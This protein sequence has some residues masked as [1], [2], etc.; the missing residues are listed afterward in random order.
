MKRAVWLGWIFMLLLFARAAHADVRLEGA[1]PEADK[2]VSLDADHMPR[3]EAVKRLADAAGWS[4]VVASSSKE[5]KELVDIHVKDQP[6]TKVL[7]LVLSEGRFIA[8]R[9]GNLVLLQADDSVSPPPVAPPPPP[10][11]TPPSPPPP[12]PPPAAAPAKRGEDRTVTGGRLEVKRDEV[13]HDV[14]VF[15]GS[16]DVYGTVTGDLAV[17]G[18]R[19]EVHPGAHIVG[20]ATTVGGSLHIRDGARVDGDV[21]VVG[22]SLRRD[23]KAQVGGSIVQGSTDDEDDHPSGKHHKGGAGFFSRVFEAMGEAFSHAA[24]LFVFG[25]IVL[26]LGSKRI[27]SLRVEVASRPMRAFALGVVGLIAAIALVTA[28]CVTIVGIPVAIVGILAGVIAAYVGVAAVVTTLGEGLLGHRTTN[29]YV[30]LAFGCALLF[31]IGALP[32][33]GTIAEIFV[34]FAGIGVI[35]ATRAAGLVPPRSGGRSSFG[36]SP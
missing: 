20:S 12:P 14:S 10:Q 26:A 1:W 2:N 11:A 4:I 7:S 28:L 8:K 33:V 35:V 9:D 30:H 31:F 3:A 24:M 25:T 22:G 29:P 23:D 5:G 27:E 17:M 6:A 16:V 34:F 15:G 36:S 19:A 18:G 13:V 21:G 32:Y